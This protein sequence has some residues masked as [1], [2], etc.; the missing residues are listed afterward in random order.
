M[1][2]AFLLSF[3]MGLLLISIAHNMYQTRLSIERCEQLV[4]QI[5][6]YANILGDEDYE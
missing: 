5:H 1:I 3:L 4:R 6:Q 2:R